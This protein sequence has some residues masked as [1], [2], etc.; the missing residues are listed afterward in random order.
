M[1]AKLNPFRDIRIAALAGIS[2]LA[3][4]AGTVGVWATTAPLAGAVIAQGQ[5]VVESNV[6]RV[7]HPSGGV[8]A[9]IRVNDG[10]RVRAGDV[11]VRLDETTVRASLAMV[12]NQL[13][14]LLA[15]QARLSAERDNTEPEVPEELA[16][17]AGDPPVAKIIAGEASL[18]AARRG[19]INGQLSQLKERV[20]QIGEEIRGLEAQAESKREQIRLIQHELEG[21]RDLYKK[22][23]VPLSRQTQLER[24][25]A[26][27]LGENGQHTADMARAK[28]RITETELQMIQLGQ[29]QRREVATEL[30]DVE[31]KIADLVER[32]VA[33]LDQ[34]R[35]IDLR[36]PQDGIVH[37]KTVHTV[38]GV[39]SP[40][41]QIMLIVPEKDG[42]VVEARIE[43]PMIDRL[44]LGQL[45]TLRFSA[46]NSATTPD[47]FGTLVRVAADLSKDQQTGASFY[48]ARVGLTAGELTKLGDKTLV[49]GM[50][51]EVYIQ[52]GTRTALAYILKPIEDQLNRSFRYD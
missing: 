37:Q 35:R 52:T 23:L 44:K 8:V 26:R 30:R 33:A 36:A 41:E 24:E 1:P 42:L 46:F 27:L 49:P 3:V 14:Q 32:R 28:G 21:V 40:G 25:A 11:L 31:T 18:L 38:G 4:T 50:P 20:A 2:A 5:V 43:P 6:R 39:I 47:L 9:D 29:E 45:V 22:N 7:Q 48:V 19:A 10:D 13:Y 17:R 12:E 16:Q 51:V 34:L 15:R